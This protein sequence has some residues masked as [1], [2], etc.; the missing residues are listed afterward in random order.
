MG[1]GAFVGFPF[2]VEGLEVIAGN[3]VMVSAFAATG[4]ERVQNSL[5]A[6]RR[7]RRPLNVEWFAVFAEDK[8]F[9]AGRRGDA[10]EN[11]TRLFVIGAGRKP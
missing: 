10:A 11:A 7:V 1:N 3:G 6:R 9:S 2:A 8:L 4:F 5:D